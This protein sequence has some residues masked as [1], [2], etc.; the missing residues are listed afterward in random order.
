VRK[1]GITPQT[2]KL[3]KDGIV[4]RIH[5]GKE[6]LSGGR[7]DLRDGGET[8]WSGHTSLG[9]GK[10]RGA[11]KGEERRFRS[12]GERAY[13]NIFK[14]GGKMSSEGKGKTGVAERAISPWGKAKTCKGLFPA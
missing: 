1:I 9:G 8:V 4:Q 5:R 3:G 14:G 12:V 7:P 2:W 10:S 11:P 13:G 6:I